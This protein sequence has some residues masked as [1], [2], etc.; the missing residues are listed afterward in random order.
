MNGK[1]YWRLGALAILATALAIPTTA[2]AEGNIAGT[3]TFD[4]DPPKRKRIRMDADPVCAGS[5]SGPVLGQEVVVGDGG[6]LANVFV[7]VKDGLPDKEYPAPSDTVIIDQKGCYYTPHV[8]G[9]QVGQPVQIL[10][11]DKTLHNVHGM[12]K[13]NAGFNFAMPK[14]VKKKDHKFDSVET[15]VYVKCDVHPWMSSYIGVLPHPFFA[16]T[17]DDGK[18]EIDGLPAGK[19]T[20]EAWQETLGTQEATVEVAADGTATVDFNFKAG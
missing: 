16:V 17:G 18:F 12:P 4:G 11:S 9:V 5:H 10:N 15:M 19:Y 14:F 20:V 7:F 8:V 3:V 6:G 1:A 13:K 2:S